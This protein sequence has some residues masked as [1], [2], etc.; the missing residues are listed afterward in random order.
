MKKEMICINCPK[1]CSLLVEEENGSYIVTGNTC[2]KGKEYALS[3]LLHPVRIITS[4][5]TLL[6]GT[7]N[8]VPVKT[9]K[10]VAKEKIFEIMPKIYALQVSAPVRIGD[11]LIEN[12]DGQNANLIA[13]QNVKTK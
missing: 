7:Q 13:T 10:P 5:V 9:D 12:I 2:P 4:T 1:G 6:N 8:R 3:E 11:I